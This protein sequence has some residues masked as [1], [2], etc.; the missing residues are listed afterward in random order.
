MS[1]TQCA[2]DKDCPSDQ[3]CSLSHECIK[4]NAFWSSVGGGI[5]I[6]IIVTFSIALLVVIVYYIIKHVKK[7]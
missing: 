3:I 6:T 7:E 5:V 1:Q 2:K 4:K